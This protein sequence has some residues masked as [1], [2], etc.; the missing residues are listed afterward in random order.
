MRYNISHKIYKEL[1]INKI[2]QQKILWQQL[3]LFLLIVSHNS[4]QPLFICVKHSHI[5]S[6]QL[7]Q[8]GL[9][10]PMNDIFIW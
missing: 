8:Q 3:S 10:S 4:S 7:S 9:H 1:Y 5:Q 2:K 6:L